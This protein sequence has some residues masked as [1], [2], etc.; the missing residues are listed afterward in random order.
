MEASRPN[1]VGLADAPRLVR[2]RGVQTGL[3]M[4]RAMS[5]GRASPAVA[6][7]TF[8]STGAPGPPLPR[9]QR[10]RRVA[11]ATTARTEA[12]A[13]Q[14]GRLSR[15]PRALRAAPLSVGRHAQSVAQH[16]LPPDSARGRASS[17]QGLAVAQEAAGGGG[18]RALLGPKR[19]AQHAGCALPD[20]PRRPRTPHLLSGPNRGEQQRQ[21]P[22]GT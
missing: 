15:H 20:A 4:Q 18:A 12:R 5:E 7:G 19:S 1:A 11:H 3:S 8:V 13:C 6:A 14:N 16:S 17:A 21:P 22:H 9:S 2:G 10:W